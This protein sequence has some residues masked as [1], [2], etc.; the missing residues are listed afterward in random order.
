MQK[1]IANARAGDG[2][3]LVVASML[4]LSGH[5]EHDDG[6]YVPDTLRDSRLGIDCMEIGEREILDSG[7]AMPG[8][9]AGWKQAATDDV[10]AAVA[11]AQREAKPD[12]FKDDW[13]PYSTPGMT[14]VH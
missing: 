14:G 7:F 8:E 9:I 6:F 11:T 3:Q 5:G 10:Q 4:R 13:N 1:A 2:P 12:P